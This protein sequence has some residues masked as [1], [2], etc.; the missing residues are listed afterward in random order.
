[1]PESGSLSR[2][3]AGEPSSVAVARVETRQFVGDIPRRDDAELIVSELATNAIRHS[4]SRERHG[5]YEL[6]LLLQPGWLRIEVVDQGTP[7]VSTPAGPSDEAIGSVYHRESGR[8]LEIVD[9]VADKW[10]YDQDTDRGTWWAEV[11]TQ[12]A[13]A[14]ELLADRGPE[15]EHDA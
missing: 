15:G 3:F 10:G 12:D 2:F 14:E 7:T 13:D 4:A 1:M 11:A 5:E 9:A 6:R 8:G